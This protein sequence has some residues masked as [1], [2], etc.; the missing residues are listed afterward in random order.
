[1]GERKTVK[2]K[3]P[4]KEG[5][6][7]KYKLQMSPLSTCFHAVKQCQAAQHSLPNPSAEHAKPQFTWVFKFRG[8][9]GEKK[10]SI[11]LIEAMLECQMWINFNFLLI[12]KDTSPH[13][14]RHKAKEN[15]HLFNISVNVCVQSHIR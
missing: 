8:L 12:I 5:P 7:L 3:A 10:I 13:T 2:V 11:P 15:C 4:N 9:K 1:M 14:L 6:L